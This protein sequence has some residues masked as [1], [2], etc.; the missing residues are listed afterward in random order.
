MKCPCEECI[1]L[2]ICLNKDRLKCSLLYKY[3]NHSDSVMNNCNALSIHNAYMFYVLTPSNK[4]EF[5]KD[6]EEARNII[7]DK[8]VRNQSIIIKIPHYVRYWILTCVIHGFKW[9]YYMK[10][11]LKLVYRWDI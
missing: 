11:K 6:K 2:A 4:I 3:L 10:G 8:Y 5:V 9:I 7:Y 1:T